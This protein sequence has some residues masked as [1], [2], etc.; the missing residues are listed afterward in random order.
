MK[1]RQ[2]LH[3]HAQAMSSCRKNIVL[4]DEKGDNYFP[5]SS[6]TE[7]DG[8]IAGNTVTAHKI[9]IG[10]TLNVLNHIYWYAE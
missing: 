6:N 5:Y 2:T 10:G 1:L 4:F 3:A 9:I 8:S 7:K